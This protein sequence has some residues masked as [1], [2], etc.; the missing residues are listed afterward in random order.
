M[1]ITVFIRAGLACRFAFLWLVLEQPLGTV[2]LLFWGRSRDVALIYIKIKIDQV[3][4][5]SINCFFQTRNIN[6]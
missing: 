6:Q 1:E 4:R 3:Q 2:H 5:M